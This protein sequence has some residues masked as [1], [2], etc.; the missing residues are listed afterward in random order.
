[1]VSRVYLLMSYGSKSCSNFQKTVDNG[2]P[3]GLILSLA[4]AFLLPMALSAWLA[5][6]PIRSSWLYTKRFLVLDHV[7]YLSFF[8]KFT[9]SSLFFIE[10]SLDYCN[11]HHWNCLP[12]KLHVFSSPGLYRFKEEMK[13]KAFTKYNQQLVQCISFS[14]FYSFN[15]KIVCNIIIPTKILLFGNWL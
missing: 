1:M 3:L 6:A 8:L 11:P 9:S 15:N 7:F 4:N 14:L 12:W 5:R 2:S 13:M 10:N